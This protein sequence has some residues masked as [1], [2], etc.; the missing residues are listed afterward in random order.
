MSLKVHS[1]TFYGVDE[2]HEVGKGVYCHDSPTMVKGELTL[3]GK[4]YRY[5]F[6][7]HVGYTGN[8]ASSPDVWLVQKIVPSMLDD[9]DLYNIAF[10]LHDWLYSVRGEVTKPMVTLERSEVDD[11]MRGVARL[12]PT[13]QASR[14]ARFRCS[15]A[16]L[17]VGLFAGGKSH[18]GNDTYGSMNKADLVLEEL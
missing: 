9:D 6:T 2:M 14:W 1:A 4:R 16:D 3:R 12:S 7:R 5:A 15:C 10:D 11:F 13:M 17:A 18:W 8:F